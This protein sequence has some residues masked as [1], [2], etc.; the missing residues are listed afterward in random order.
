MNDIEERLVRDIAAVIGRRLGLPVASVPQEEFGPFGPLFALDQS[1]SGHHART[2][3]GWRPT[4]P[5]LLE[6][7]ENIQP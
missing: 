6:D 4:H 2:V 5:A 1:A 3:L 7:L